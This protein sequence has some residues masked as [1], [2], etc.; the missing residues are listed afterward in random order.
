M[1]EV[2]NSRL[3][4]KLVRFILGGRL[5]L[6]PAMLADGAG[7]V[8]DVDMGT[9]EWALAMGNTFPNVLVEGI[10][11]S[12]QMPIWT[13][14]LFPSQSQMP[15]R[16]G[17]GMKTTNSISCANYPVASRTGTDSLHNAHKICIEDNE[18]LLQYT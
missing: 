3:Y 13:S 16:T 11:L 10:D 12:D 14:P 18:K 6:A 9:R 1:K 7:R 4:H 8:L 15:K 17:R 2:E 5:Y